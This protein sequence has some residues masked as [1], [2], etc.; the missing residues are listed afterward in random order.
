MKRTVIT[1]L[2]IMFAA[3]VAHAAD[4]AA[5]ADRFVQLRVSGRHSST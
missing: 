3:V 2:F 5:L 1:A 4:V